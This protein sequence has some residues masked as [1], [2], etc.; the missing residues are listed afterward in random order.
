MDRLLADDDRAGQQLGERLGE[1][2]LGLAVGVRDQVVR[3]ALL[4]DLVRGQLPEA[5]H[6][7][8]GGRLPDRFFD[9]GRAAREKLVDG[10]DVFD[11][12]SMT[13]RATDNPRPSGAL[14]VELP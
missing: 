9:V 14:R 13:T 8:G 12:G 2:L 6:D 10:F 1:V 7:L 11:H 3:A 4:V 5:R